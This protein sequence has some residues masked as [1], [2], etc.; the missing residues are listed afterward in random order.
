MEINYQHNPQLLR[1]YLYYRVFLSTILLGMFESGL[2]QNALGT[3]S[4]ELFRWTI[5]LYTLFT[6][7]SLYLFR[8]SLLLRSLHRLTFLLV[9]DL[10]AML[11][12]IHSSGG[13]D[14]GLGY[15]LL[16]C[17]A[18]ASVFIRGQLALAYAALI[19]LFLIAETI[20]IT[21]DPSD[22]T[23]GLFS[24]G[25]LGILVFATTI[26]FLY[27]TEKIRSSDIA[28]HTQAKYAEHLEKL[29]QH[30]VTRMRTGVV[31]TDND[32]NIELIND[33]A[34][35]LLDLPQNTEYIG[36]P[37]SGFSNLE[38]MLKEWQRNPII[39]LPKVHTLRDGHE[40][41]I[42]FAQLE[43]S[44]LT[45]TILYIEDHRAIVQQAQQLKLASLGRLTA[46][47]AHEVRNPLG[48]IAHA[49]QLLKESDSITSADTRLTEIILQHS[50]RVNQIINNTL[51]LSRRKEPKPVLVDLVDWVPSFI[52]SFQIAVE[53]DIDIHINQPVIQAKVDPSQLQQ[54]LTNL[55][56][57]GLRYSKLH[58]GHARIKICA[59]IS[60]NDHTPYIEVIDY[61]KGVPEQQLQQIFDPFFTTDDKGTGLGL[62]IS[63][64][65]CEINQASL[66]YMRT[67]ERLSCFRISFSHHQ[68]KI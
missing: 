7:G 48:A 52:N 40:V 46:S 41:R 55:C 53:G 14:S 24:T 60:A 23:K 28:A 36:A 50:E 61:G 58:T 1:V 25:I 21:K 17:T 66:H 67:E 29:A 68:R 54:V 45:R 22:L 4:P 31:V 19:T 20:Y 34:L 30:I 33:S 64:E 42:N 56:E 15:L 38:E 49:A 16:V 12:V 32:N 18:M 11:L 27:L 47:I 26:T 62:Y 6:V 59:G 9:L 13:P 65:L 39:G 2:G 57:N 51:I 44:E 8:P 35:Q 10:I 3:H 43:T 63:K 37:L 5:S